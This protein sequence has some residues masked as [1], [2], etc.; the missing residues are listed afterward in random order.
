VAETNTDFSAQYSEASFWEKTRTYA[1]QAGE[2]VLEPA[3]KMYYA[4]LDGDTPAWAKTTIV[5]SLG[6]FISPL[7]AVPDLIPVAGYTDDF[8]VL[9]AA[10]AAVAAH[11]KDEHAKKA[12]ETLAQWFS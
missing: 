5:A 12:R 7:D 3:L 2:G 4:A 6:Y 9:F 11:I 1:K 8:G 10:I